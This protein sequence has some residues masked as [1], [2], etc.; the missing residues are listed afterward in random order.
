MSRDSAGNYTLPLAP[1]VAGDT[2]ESVWANTS[3]SDIAAA[4][5]DSLSRSGQGG[6]T[7]TFKIADG[8]VSAPGIAFTNE[9]QTGFY[10]AGTGDMRA[11]VQGVD[12]FRWSTANGV[13]VYKDA[14]WDDVLTA[15]DAVGGL[16][17][18]TGD[19]NSLRWEAGANEWQ[20][21][22]TLV[23]TGGGTVAGTGA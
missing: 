7:V 14:A 8:T 5:T 12:T 22:T 20:E 17:T 3:L 9:P 18:G 19:G 21:N 23:I 4:L 15:S 2:I 11:A 1:V 10:R 6:M 13:Q 16:P